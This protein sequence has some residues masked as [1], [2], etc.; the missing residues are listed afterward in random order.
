MSTPLPPVKVINH[1]YIVV[2]RVFFMWF[3]KK[4]AKPVLTLKYREQILFQDEISL[5]P[6]KESSILEKSIEY[7]DDPEPCY[8]HR[9]AVRIRLIAEFE[10]LLKKNPSLL[11]SLFC[12]LD[13]EEIDAWDYH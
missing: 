7:Y 11:S 8:I 3:Q 1:K 5:L 6:F 4:A 12:H 13:F 2:E 9:N 10:V